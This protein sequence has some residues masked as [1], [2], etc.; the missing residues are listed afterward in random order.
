MQFSKIPPYL[1]GFNTLQKQLWEGG[2]KEGGSEG[3]RGDGEER[4][5]WEG[6]GVGG[7][8]RRKGEEGGG[9]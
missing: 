7:G 1:M 3:R 6:G 5:V 2:E 9:R 4:G 8:G